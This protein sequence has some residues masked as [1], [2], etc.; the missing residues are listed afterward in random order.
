[1]SPPDRSSGTSSGYTYTRPRMTL[2]TVPA[3]L[4]WRGGG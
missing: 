2:T 3:P 4:D 1:M